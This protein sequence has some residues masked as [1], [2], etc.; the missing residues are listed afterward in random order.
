[1]SEFDVNVWEFFFCVVGVAEK[2]S[3]SPA[4]I[5]L[6]DGE[7]AVAVAFGVVG[8]EEGGVGSVG[9]DHGEFPGEV[10]GVLDSCVA[11]EGT[12]KSG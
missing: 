3:G 6:V 4:F 12:Y 8:F 10:M 11:A 2:T 7:E 9:E 5:G 1:L